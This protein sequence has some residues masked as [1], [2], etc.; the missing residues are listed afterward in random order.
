MTEPVASHGRGGGIAP[1]LAFVVA[2]TASAGCSL[3]RVGREEVSVALER[4]FQARP[5]TAEGYARTPA[6]DESPAVK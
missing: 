5:A 6:A 4:H 2:V 1:A 3:N